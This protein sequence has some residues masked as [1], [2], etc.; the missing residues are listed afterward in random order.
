MILDGERV[1]EDS[2][3]G[4]GA[5]KGKK[6]DRVLPAIGEDVDDDALYFPL[7]S[8]LLIT[9]L[10]TYFRTIGDALRVGY[11]AHDQLVS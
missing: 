9:L 4:A 6:T 7:V 11:F 3:R 5:S 2:E 8:S 10:F 1:K